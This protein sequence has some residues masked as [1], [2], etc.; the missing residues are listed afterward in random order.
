MSK[1]KCVVH[2]RRVLVVRDEDPFAPHELKSGSWW[3]NDRHK[4]LGRM[5]HREDGTPCAPDETGWS[6]AE[7]NTGATVSSREN[8]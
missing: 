2:H 1:L 5:L 3:V 7:F 8:Y 6:R 4:F